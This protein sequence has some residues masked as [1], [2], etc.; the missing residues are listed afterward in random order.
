MHCKPAHI[1]MFSIP[2]HG[3]VNPS[4][5]VVRELVSRGH[6]VSYAIPESF[7]ATVA[8]TGAEPKLWTSV[9]PTEDDEWP[10]ELVDQLR[11]FFDDA[12]QALPQLADAYRD[13]VPDLVLHDIGSFPAVV[14]A[15]GWGVPAVQLSPCMVAWDGYVEEVMEPTRELIRQSPGGAEYQDAFA[16]WLRANGITEPN[17][18]RV[19]RLPRR[20]VVLIPKA[21]QPHADRVDESVYSFVG[22][23]QGDRADQGEWHRPGNADQVLLVSLGSAFTNEPGFYRDCIE[24]FGGLAGWHV[25]LQIG[26]FVD[27]AELGE[28]P[29]NFEV[30]RWVPQQ[31]ILR[32]ADAFITHAGMGGAQEGLA[33]GVPMVAVPQAADQ[34]MNAEV[35]QEL[36]VGRHLPKEEAGPEKL[37]ELVLALVD[38]PAVVARL[39]EVRASMATEGGARRAA[40]L[41]EAE[42]N[43]SPTEG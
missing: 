12:V 7:A 11:P 23:C 33:S 5:G 18:D 39:A 14:L 4:L 10:E 42:L 29:A 24:A 43:P 13:D 36:G 32:Q 26:K 27:E 19:F 38:D 31:A 17:S 34:F 22:S 37:R 30:H 28:I 15:R 6:R 1:A 40:D 9:L 8:A 21:M 41:I 2:A 25:V 16:D 20:S 3:H 35:L